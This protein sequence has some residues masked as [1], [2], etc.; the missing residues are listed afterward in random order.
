MIFI[1]SAASSADCR[2]RES[3]V[4]TQA[5]RT[6]NVTVP[7]Q[8]LELY[9]SSISPSHLFSCSLAS[10][11]LPFM[12]LPFPLP[13]LP[14]LFPSR[15]SPF[16]IRYAM[17]ARVLAMAM[18]PCLSVCLS[19]V[20]VETDKRIGLVLAWELPSTYPTLCYKEIQVSSKIRVLPSGTLD[21]EKFFQHHID[22]RS[23]LS[24]ST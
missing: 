1:L 19:Q 24:L 5:C 8:L 17:L 13:F 10:P 21:L 15:S 14:F 3:G 11:C 6:F 12:S 20:G 9:T 2:H 18:Y 23:V 4:E 22:R 7:T 16:C